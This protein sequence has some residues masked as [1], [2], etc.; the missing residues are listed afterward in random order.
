MVTREGSPRPGFMNKILYF[1]LLTEYFAPSMIVPCLCPV[2]LHTEAHRHGGN[3][4]ELSLSLRLGSSFQDGD[5]NVVWD[6][7]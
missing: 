6:L 2:I 5:V 4:S 1:H 7:L 3:N